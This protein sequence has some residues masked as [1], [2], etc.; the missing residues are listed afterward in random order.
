M[1]LGPQLRQLEHELSLLRLLER[2][3]ER[4]LLDRSGVLEAAVDERLLQFGTER[5]AKPPDRDPSGERDGEAEPLDRTG[6]PRNDRSAS[7]ERSSRGLCAFWAES[8][9]RSCIAVVVLLDARRAVSI[10]SER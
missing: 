4:P 8:G 1:G 5:E 2:G 3:R 10:G 6:W 9:P 7:A